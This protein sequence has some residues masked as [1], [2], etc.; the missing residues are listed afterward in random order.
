MSS[1]YETVIGLEAHVQ[2]ATQSKAFCGDATAFGAEPNTQ[3]SIVSLGYPGT[4]PRLNKKQLAYAI[5][6]GLATKGQIT[7]RTTFDRKNYVYADLPKGYQI[8]QDRAPI[9]IGGHLPIRLPDGSSKHIRLHH[10]HMEED[11]GK[12]IHSAGKNYTQIDLNRAGVPLLEVVTEPD[13][14]SA[15]EVAA[16]M[17][18]LRRLV[19]YLGISDGN[20]QEGSLR[21]D[22][23]ISIRP[24]GSKTYGTRTEVKNLNSMRYARQAIAFEVQ[25]QTELLDEGELVV[26]ETRQF[27]PQRGQTFSLRT[28]EEAHDYRY[29]PDP[30]L[31]P[32]QITKK[33]ID[34]QR[35]RASQLPWLAYAHIYELLENDHKD[36]EN[37]ID[38][39]EVY[40]WFSQLMDAGLPPKHTAKLV[41][42]K[43]L[44]W[45]REHDLQPAQC[46]LSAEQ[47]GKYLQLIESGKVAAAQANAKLLPALLEQPEH[48]PEKL[49][50]ELGLMQLQ[51]DDFLFRLA[52]V[53][54][55]EFPDK[56]AAYKKGKKGLIGFFMGEVMKR[57]QG[58]AEPKATRA[59]LQKLLENDA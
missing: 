53:V 40:F 52:Q 2:L 22:V 20:M 21:C 29:F 16:F 34:E 9:S 12:S 59:I 25:R 13:L 18:E 57:S 38:E 58:K 35:N 42:N 49:A 4:L 5:R 24:H 6:L 44:P 11:A 14:R 8:T 56:V 28:K 45:L 47:I 30:D 33:Q 37:I 46:P 23:N 36:T 17:R 32:V 39:P 31:P 51:D 43:L 10:I 26:Q 48:K 50:D 19:R 54:T 1:P 15:D 27:D 55:S 3:L 7:K 41:L